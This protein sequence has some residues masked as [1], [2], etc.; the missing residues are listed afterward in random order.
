[1]D[2]KGVLQIHGEFACQSGYLAFMRLHV[3]TSKPC[4][5]ESQGRYVR[6]DVAVGYS[7]FSHLPLKFLLLVT[8]RQSMVDKK[9][10]NCFSSVVKH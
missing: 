3:E 4:S 10:Q 8:V 2:L 5:S 1:M 9:T 6:G 7:A